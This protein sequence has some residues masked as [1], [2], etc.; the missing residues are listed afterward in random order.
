MGLFKT[1]ANLLMQWKIFPEYGFPCSNF[2]T[3][4][5]VDFTRPHCSFCS[6]GV[7][8]GSHGTV[9][10]LQV[11]FHQEVLAVCNIWHWSL[12]QFYDHHVAQCCKS[13]PNGEIYLKEQFIQGYSVYWVSNMYASISGIFFLF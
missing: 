5:P 4:K 2:S 1:P 7:S 12:H 9:C 10:F 6:R 11:V 3:H 13:S 8:S